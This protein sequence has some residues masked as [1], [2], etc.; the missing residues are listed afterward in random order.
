MYLILCIYYV[1]VRS[2][3]MEIYKIPMNLRAAYLS[4]HRMTNA[5]L[6]KHGV[7]ADQFVCLSILFEKDGLTQK[8]LVQSATSDPNTIRAMLVLLENQGFIARDVHP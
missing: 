7:T 2:G 3:P 6:S 8:E 1:Y 4:M 5:H